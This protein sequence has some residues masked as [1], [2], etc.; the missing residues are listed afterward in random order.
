MEGRRAGAVVAARFAGRAVQL[1]VG[2]ALERF[3]HHVRRSLHV[4][5]VASFEIEDFV[6]VD[7]LER[8]GEV[9]AFP[10]EVH[11]ESVVEIGH[12]VAYDH[13]VGVFFEDA[14]AVGVDETEVA[15]LR[16]VE[17]RVGV[18]LLLVVEDAVLNHQVVAADGLS[19]AGDVVAAGVGG[20]LDDV[21]VFIAEAQ[22][23]VA[24]E[25]PV[26]RNGVGEVAER[27]ARGERQLDAFVLHRT[28]V[29]VRGRE[30]R[31]RRDGNVEKHVGGLRIVEVGVQSEQSAPEADV[32]ADVVLGVLL[33]AQV[34]VGDLFGVDL[35]GE[36][37]AQVDVRRAVERQV[38]RIADLGIAR[39]ADAGA[40]L[41]VVDPLDAAHEVF[42]ADAP[43]DAYR[44]EITP[45]GVGS[46]A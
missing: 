38:F 46:E 36:P 3:A 23:L 10:G 43:A 28:D 33:P 32:Y 31:Y 15:H 6:A 41:H 9:E 16:R 29:H 40:E 14:V 45:A 13:P 17:M 34:V 25:R 21:G 37:V 19:D 27:A 12:V 22:H 35:R 20:L 5:Q 26:G 8:C 44:R 1:A 39:L 2:V 30:A 4:K 24:V 7:P 18:Q 42:V 11:R